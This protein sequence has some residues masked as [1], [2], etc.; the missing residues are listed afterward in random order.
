MSTPS[1]RA[2]QPGRGAPDRSLLLRRT[3]PAVAVAFVAFVI[4]VVC[5]AGHD[6]SARDLVTAYA[7]AWNRGDY[8]RMYASVDAATQRRLPVLDF[9]D[10]HR[11]AM[12]TATGT[13]L[14]TGK[15]RRQGD[16][17]AIPVTVRTRSFGVVRGSVLVSTDG[18]GEKTRIVWAPNLTFPGVRRGEELTRQTQMPPRANILARDGTALTK[19]GQRGGTLGPISAETVGA[20]GPIPAGRRQEAE[21]L[22]YPPDAQ[23]GTSGLEL[24]LDTRL[25]GTPGGRLLAGSRVLAS[26]P[27]KRAKDVTSTIDP[28]IEQTAI[29]AL[30]GRDGGV[31]AMKPRTG[32]IVAFAGSAY[33]VLQPPGSTFKLVT[34][35]GAL[36]AKIVKPS[37]T[38]PI[39]TAATLSGVRLSNAGGEAC[40][41]TLAQSFAESCNSVFAPMGAKL[42]PQGLYR[43]AVLYGFNRSPGIPG[44]ATSTIPPPDQLGD[45]LNVGSSAIGQGEVQ[46][47]PLQMAW[48]SAAI[49]NRG[50]LPRLTL[51]TADVHGRAPTTPTSTRGVALIVQTLMLGAVQYGTGTAAQIPGVKVAGKTGTAE[52]RSTQ[53]SPDQDPSECG[54]GGPEDTDA[55][56]TAYAPTATPKVAVG[57]MLIGAGAGGDTAAPV[58]HDVLVTALGPNAA[59]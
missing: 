32:E 3:L 17:W 23:V 57:V 4:G 8:A 49:A 24:A 2:A 30:G 43:Q 36:N 33:S 39:E 14:T 44:A 20:I 25:A 28:A 29:T 12:V 38:F 46:A 16:A 41:G 1:R 48:V 50:R 26:G 31:L 40:G 45:D 7:K 19:D 55:W 13:R 58:A 27:A 52:L 47:T 21:A 18:E 5:G 34:V 37:D 22:G 6:T 56:F 15:P 53:C 11:A 42:G 9:A 54:T 10:A 51:D 59:R 35:T